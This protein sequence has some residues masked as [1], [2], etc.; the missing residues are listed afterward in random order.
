[1]EE[2]AKIYQSTTTQ[3]FSATWHISKYIDSDLYQ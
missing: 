3:D 1:M 2:N